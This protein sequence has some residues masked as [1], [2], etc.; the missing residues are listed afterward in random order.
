MSTPNSRASL[1]TYAMR[2]LGHPVIKLNVDPD[3]LDDRIDEA[4]G[5]FTQYH[6]DATKIVYL[7]V[8]ADANIISNT[9][10]SQ[11][12]SFVMPNTVIGVVKVFPLLD[13]VAV[14]GVNSGNFNIFDMNYQLRLNELFDFTSADYVYFELAQQHIRT[15]ELLF[16]GEPP[17]RYNR[18][19]NIV[20]VDGKWDT[21]NPGA[22]FVFETYSTLPESNQNFWND[23]WL[24]KYT[25]CLFKEQ[26]ANNLK[27]FKGTKLPGGV[28]LDGQGMY[29][30]A[31]AEKA[32]LEEELHSRYEIPSEFFVG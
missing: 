21:Y 4:I 30:E 24:K 29:S 3:Q 25:T 1:R 20:Y 7:S 13:A 6:M 11:Y 31:V 8:T 15:L 32:Q 18:H 28:E 16:V 17:I 9:A 19:E 27:K 22:K 12:H 5:L 26:W 10:N 14:G 2:K 23:N